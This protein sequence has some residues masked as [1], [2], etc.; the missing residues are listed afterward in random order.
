M[1][2]CRFCFPANTTLVQYM[3]YP[4]H[5]VHLA[6]MDPTFTT[7]GTVLGLNAWYEIHIQ[8]KIRE[9]L[10][11]EHFH[12]KQHSFSAAKEAHEEHEECVLDEL[13]GLL[14]KENTTSDMS[15]LDNFPTL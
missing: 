14:Q 8:L 13:M 15:F 2:Y 10:P 7:P 5:T 3:I 1:K 4:G 9:S 12:C 11:T 6:T